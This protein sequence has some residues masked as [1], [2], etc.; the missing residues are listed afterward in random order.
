MAEL[1]MVTLELCDEKLHHHRSILEAVT[2][3]VNDEEKYKLARA[4]VMVWERI[5]FHVENGKMVT[6]DSEGRFHLFPDD[7]LLSN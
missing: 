6:I 4:Y 5:R 7:E 1:K 2:E 3:C